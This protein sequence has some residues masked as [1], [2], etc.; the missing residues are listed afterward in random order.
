[1]RK[2]TS[3]FVLL[4]ATS[5][6]AQKISVSVVDELYA[7]KDVSRG[8][9]DLYGFLGVNYYTATFEMPDTNKH[10]VVLVMRS[11]FM[12]SV[13]AIDTL[14]DSSTLRKKIVGGFP[15]DPKN[16]ASFMARRTDS[17]H[18]ELLFNV[19]RSSRRTITLTN[20]NTSYMLDEG[21]RSMGKA[22]TME[23]GKPMPIMVLT[24]PYPDPPPPQEVKIYRYCFG[25]DVPPDQWP[26][27]FG[28]PH[29]YI[30][31]LTVLP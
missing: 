19:G 2:V 26:T 9:K 12:D 27:V 13:P 15:W 22:V 25:A 4:V 5:L 6:Y 30:F 8:L 18:Y 14:W 21:L 16:G 31:E 7:N 23:L 3:L 28:V 11:V 17:L 29:L 10:D 20:A 24:Q 1:M